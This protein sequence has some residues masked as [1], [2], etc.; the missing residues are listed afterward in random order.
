MLK[1]GNNWPCSFKEKVKNIQ[2]FTDDARRQSKC[3]LS[4]LGDLKMNGFG[5]L[6][7]GINLIFC[8]TSMG[9]TLA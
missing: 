3:H 5:N 2:F 7:M 8:F 6:S 4:D 9:K 1:N